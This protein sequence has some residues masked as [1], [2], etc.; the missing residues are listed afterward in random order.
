[1]VFY[2]SPSFIPTLLSSGAPERAPDVSGRW[3]PTYSY[4]SLSADLLDLVIGEPLLGATESLRLFVADTVVAHVGALE[5]GAVGLS[6]NV[7]GLDAATEGAGSWNRLALKLAWDLLLNT[8]EN[9]RGIAVGLRDGATMRGLL[10]IVEEG[11]SV[12]REVLLLNEIVALRRVHAVELAN[13]LGR[14]GLYCTKHTSVTESYL[15]FLEL[16][17][18]SIA[19]KWKPSCPLLTA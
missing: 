19:N 17:C 5:R 2:H 4:A 16:D 7:V 3:S 9:F 14:H 11:I 1:M 6:E 10:L 12:L 18:I 15:N 8:V 13:G